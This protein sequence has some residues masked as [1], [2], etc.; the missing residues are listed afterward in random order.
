M[1]TPWFSEREKEKE[2]KNLP[3][4]QELHLKKMGEK[5]NHGGKIQL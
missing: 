2:K 5:L 4:L 3:G 1:A